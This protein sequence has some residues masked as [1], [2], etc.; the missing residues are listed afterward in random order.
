LEP[1]FLKKPQTFQISEKIHC[2]KDCCESEKTIE[3]EKSKEKH[4]DHKTTT[5]TTSEADHYKKGCC[6]SEKPKE[7]NDHCEKECCESQQQPEDD[8]KKG[9]CES[10]KPKE[11]NDYCEKECCESQKLEDHCKKDCCESEKTAVAVVSDTSIEQMEAVTCKGS[12]CD[13]NTEAPVE[14][15]LEGR[16][17]DSGQKVAFTIQGMDCSS[18]ATSLE[19]TLRKQSGVSWAKVNFLSKLGE[20]NFDSEFID[21]ASLRAIIERSGYK[22]I[23]VMR[24][25]AGEASIG[26]LV[27]LKVPEQSVELILAN[28]L[29]CP[30]ALRAEF[31][32]V[33]DGVVECHFDP[34]VTGPRNILRAAETTTATV[35]IFKPESISGERAAQ[36]RELT[37]ILVKFVVGACLAVPLVLIAFFLP[38]DAGINAS[39]SRFVLGHVTIAM[40]VSFVLCTVAMAVIGPALYKSA[41]RS[42]RYQRTFNMNFLVMMSST[43]AY[44]YSFAIFIALFTSP[45]GLSAEV[46][47]ETPAILLTLVTGGTLLEKIAMRKSVSFI[48]S[49]RVWQE[50]TAV[51]IEAKGE[52]SVIDADLIGRGDLIKLVPGS[53]IPVD[54]RVVEGTSSVDESLLTGEALPVKKGVN[55]KVFAGTINQ[56]GLLIVSATKMSSESTLAQMCAFVDAALAERLPIERIA[57]RVSHYF[58]PIAICL[59]VLTFFV[60]FALAYTGVVVTTTFSVLFALR[61]AVAVLVVSCPCAIALAVPLSLLLQPVWRRKTGF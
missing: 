3:T 42:L 57:D 23:P 13:R 61:F 28:I 22:A 26:A 52:E 15:I 59:G 11:K 41:Y 17:F 7:K 34:D 40:V 60:W 53:R 51:L 39:L 50:S 2:E 12:C 38:L 36:R 55:A 45:P 44:L 35:S 58:V 19:S 10:E 46:F 31:S 18:C 14:S 1:V 9:C 54:G 48:E 37:T 49:L 25:V 27:L 6:E 20:V 33:Y 32:L 16:G 56:E 47:F 29:A 4:D 21:V 5:T 43:I 8:C 30:G 24:P